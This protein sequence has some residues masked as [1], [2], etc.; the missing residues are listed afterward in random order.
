MKVGDLLRFRHPSYAAKGL[1]RLTAVGSR[2]EGELLGRGG[3]AVP[4]ATPF[5]LYYKGVIPVW[6]D[7]LDLSPVGRF[8]YMRGD[9]DNLLATGM[10]DLIEGRKS[11]TR[12]IAMNDEIVFE[13]VWVEVTIEMDLI[14]LTEVGAVVFLD[15]QDNAGLWYKTG[16]DGEPFVQ[17]KGPGWAACLHWGNGYRL[18]FSKALP[19]VPCCIKV[20]VKALKDYSEVLVRDMHLAQTRLDQIRALQAYVEH[21]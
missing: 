16:L 11:I 4:Y 2:V 20:R 18:Q 13:D 12:E 21:P 19:T 7:A 17:A 10:A 3:V 8:G 9:I 1:Y 15:G 5:I 14:L 6:S